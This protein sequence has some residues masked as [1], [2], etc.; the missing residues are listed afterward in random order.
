M[1]EQEIKV[2]QV[3][4]GGHFGA[5]RCEIMR[6]DNVHGPEIKWLDN[7]MTDN[8][9]RFTF[10]KSFKLITDV[11]G[12][13]KMSEPKGLKI[14]RNM[15]VGAGDLE[16]RVIFSEGDE[17]VCRNSDGLFVVDIDD[18]G[19]IAELPT[20]DIPSLAKKKVT[21]KKPKKKKKT[22]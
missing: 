4:E 17:F 18:V 15:L 13:S 12:G 1:S 22:K 3:W 2:G 14:K 5:R 19:I 16:G 6:F 11:K 7:G 9:T 21:P 20:K 8:W 10:L